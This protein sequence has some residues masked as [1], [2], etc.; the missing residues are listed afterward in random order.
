MIEMDQMVQKD[1]TCNY[2]CLSPL[3]PK[4]PLTSMQNSHSLSFFERD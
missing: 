3:G 1:M 2:A 4:G